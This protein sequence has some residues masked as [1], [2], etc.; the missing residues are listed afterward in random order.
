MTSQTLFLMLNSFTDPL[1]HCDITSQIL[2]IPFS[3]QTVLLIPD[4]FTDSPPHPSITSQIL[5][6]LTLLHTPTSH[7]DI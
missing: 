7:P 3:S 5:L 4:W 6:F 1:P 2:L